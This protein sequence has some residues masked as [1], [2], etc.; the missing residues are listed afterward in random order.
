MQFKKQEEKPKYYNFKVSH[1]DIYKKVLSFEFYNE[2]LK[3]ENTQMRNL[4]ES[5]K[6]W[7]L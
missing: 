1:D 6:L 3:T 2:K 5:K 4:I 7:N